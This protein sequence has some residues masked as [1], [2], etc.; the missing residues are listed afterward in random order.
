MLSLHDSLAFGET[1]VITTM[2]P[3]SQTPL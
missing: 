2:G 3:C 1:Q